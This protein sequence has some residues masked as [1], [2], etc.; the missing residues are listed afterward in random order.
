ME[1]YRVKK[2]MIDGEVANLFDSDDESGLTQEE[3]EQRARFW[4]GKNRKYPSKKDTRLGRRQQK[5]S[6]SNND[7]HVDDDDA[8]GSQGSFAMVTT[9]GTFRASA[10]SAM[11]MFSFSGNGKQTGEAAAAAA[12]PDHIMQ[13]LSQSELEMDQMEA[14]MLGHERNQKQHP[15]QT[16][17]EQYQT[18]KQHCDNTAAI[19]TFSGEEDDGT[20]NRGESVLPQLT[21]KKKKETALFCTI[22]IVLGLMMCA[23]FAVGGFIMYRN[24]LQN[25]E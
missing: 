8:S 7:C 23:L 19:T 16:Q 14:D 25:G 15:K 3:K 2:V 9:A 13:D 22:G 18:K 5:N 1:G 6:S 11:G 17:K 12:T 4:G 10:I 21:K 24:K 20:K